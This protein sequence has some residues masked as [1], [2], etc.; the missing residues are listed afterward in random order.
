MKW[1]WRAVVAGGLVL[2]SSIVCWAV[3]FETMELPSLG[4]VSC[5]APPT[6]WHWIACGRQE[7]SS[8]RRAFGWRRSL[9]EK[10]VQTG[11][12]A[13][14]LVPALSQARSAETPAP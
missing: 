1:I 2:S 11:A 7:L 9:R 14:R 12:S 3:V 13:P 6:L 8:A 4:W 10:D 5:D